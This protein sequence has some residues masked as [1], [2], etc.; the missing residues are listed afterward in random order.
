M[1]SF[2]SSLGSES[3]VP[4]VAGWRELL[5]RA[6]S[7]SGKMS[8]MIS[9]SMLVGQGVQKADRSQ[10]VVKA[11]RARNAATAPSQDAF[12]RMGGK[13]SPF[14]ECRDRATFWQWQG[15]TAGGKSSPFPRCRDRASFLSG[16]GS[17]ELAC[18]KGTQL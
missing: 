2:G 6:S 18:V 7:K 8:L 10:L 3:S 12:R 9:S 13:S 16:K 15:F 4:E 1:R 14:T 11:G 5:H 17:L